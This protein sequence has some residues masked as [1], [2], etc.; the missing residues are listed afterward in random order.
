MG[1]FFPARKT[2]NRDGDYRPTIT[3]K[4]L[5]FKQHEKILN[6][7][8]E[9]KLCEDQIYINKNFSEY[10]VEKRKNLFKRAKQIRE[11]GEFAKV[12]YNRLILY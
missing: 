12:I 7:Y 6:S 10:L 9:L 8:R 5:N 1:Q 3:A 4:F 2:G 11:R